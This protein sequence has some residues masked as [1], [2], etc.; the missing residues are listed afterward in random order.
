MLFAEQFGKYINNISDDIANTEIISIDIDRKRNELTLYLKSKEL[1]KRSEIIALQ[2]EVANLLKQ[3]RVDIIPKY[4][5]DMFKAEYFFELLPSLNVAVINGYFN[6]AKPL[7]A[8]NTLTITLSHGGASILQ[9]CD[10]PLHIQTLIKSEFSF[11]P[12][13]EFDGVLEAAPKE[14]VSDVNVYIPQK[15]INTA[16]I[17]NS[18]SKEISKTNKK[19]IELPNYKIYDGIK[20]KGKK[21][22]E[23][24]VPLSKVNIESGRVVVSGEIFNQDLR[25]SKD[26]SKIILSIDITD[27]TSSITLKIIE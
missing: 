24:P 1:L 14:I 2:K 20:I 9:K 5:P 23:A 17:K 8:N 18:V 10:I 21:I 26:G 16:E 15:N 19:V 4:T 13:V 6:D 7:F 22:A 25:Y 27:Y 3:N 12:Q 11:V